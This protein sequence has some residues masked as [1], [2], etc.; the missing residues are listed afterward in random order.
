MKLDILQR[1]IASEEDTSFEDSFMSADGSMVGESTWFSL[2]QQSSDTVDGDTSIMSDPFGPNIPVRPSAPEPA[3]DT[4]F[5]ESDSSSLDV[6]NV[7]DISAN[8]SI[9]ED[10]DEGI[11]ID[12]G[13]RFVDNEAEEASED[14]EEEGSE[15]EEEEDEGSEE[16]SE[17]DGDE[18]SESEPESSFAESSFNDTASTVSTPPRPRRTLSPTKKISLAKTP[19]MTPAKATKALRESTRQ[20]VINLMSD[21]EDMVVAKDTPAK[22]KRTLGKRVV[23]DDEMEANAG[24]V[25]GAEVRRMVR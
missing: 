4:S 7:L 3:G 17:V 11:S 23:M 22:K 13:A 15:E 2:T 21:E 8:E 24:P 12:T 20:P 10:V 16:G 9:D 5:A 25:G 6:L 18:I 1:T 14:D 19:K